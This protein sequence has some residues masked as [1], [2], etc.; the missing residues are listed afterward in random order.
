MHGLSYGYGPAADRQNGIRT[1][2]VHGARY[3]EA[4]QRLIDR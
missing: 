4:S 2:E 3:P 1:I